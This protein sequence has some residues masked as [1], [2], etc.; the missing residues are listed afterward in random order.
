VDLIVN[1]NEIEICLHE[2]IINFQLRAVAETGGNFR[3]LEDGEYRLLEDGE[4]RLLE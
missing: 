2:D 1:D 3:L 4:F